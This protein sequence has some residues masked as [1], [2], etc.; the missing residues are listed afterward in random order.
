MKT[1]LKVASA[2]GLL[3]LAAASS[4]ALAAPLPYLTYEQFAGWD[5]QTYTFTPGTTGM[6]GLEFNNPTGGDPYPANTYTNIAWYGTTAGNP[7]S[8]IDIISHNTSNAPIPPSTLS[9]PGEWKAGEWGVITTLTQ[10]NNILSINGNGSNVPNTLWTVDAVANLNILDNNSNLLFSDLNNVT[11]IEFWETHNTTNCASPTPFSTNCDDIFRVTAIDFAP[12]G[13]VHE[14]YE[15]TI[16]FTL[17]PGP[18]TNDGVDTGLST[19]VCTAASPECAGFGIPDGEIWV[20]TPEYAPGTS[21]IYVA[22][23]Y[24]VTAVPEPSIVA[25]FALGMLGVGFAARRRK[26]DTVA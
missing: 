19:I 8:S 1:M 4:S 14:G 12:I 2:A 10:T 18:I 20:F 13:F 15:Y 17:I 6:T 3:G 23:S 11:S 16:D 9:T 21:T 24:S 25:L 5:D 26:E 22:M 7:P